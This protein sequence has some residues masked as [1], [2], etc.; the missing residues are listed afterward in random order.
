MPENYCSCR[1]NVRGKYK[2]RSK[3]SEDVKRGKTGT[4]EVECLGKT[5]H[6]F[7]AI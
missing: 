3:K 1:K 5:K 4:P 7:I 6:D 2:Q